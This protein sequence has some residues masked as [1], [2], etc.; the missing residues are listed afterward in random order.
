MEWW[1]IPVISAPD[2]WT[3]EDLEVKLV[4]DTQQFRFEAGLF[5]KRPQLNHL[6]KKEKNREEKPV[7]IDMGRCSQKKEDK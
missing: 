6:L 1:H 3:Q 2:R 7:T 4:S 5:C